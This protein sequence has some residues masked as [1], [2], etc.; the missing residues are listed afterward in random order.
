MFRALCR[1]SSGTS[2]VFAAS[3]LYT[4]VETARGGGGGGADTHGPPGGGAH[5]I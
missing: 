3:G 2:T 5:P 4:L 1:S